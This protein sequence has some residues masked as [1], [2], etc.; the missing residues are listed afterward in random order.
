MPAHW[1]QDAKYKRRRARA[2]GGSSYV[3]PSRDICPNISP[4]EAAYI[5]IDP[6]IILEKNEYG[7]HSLIDIPVYIFRIWLCVQEAQI[8]ERIRQLTP[9]VREEILKLYHSVMD[10]KADYT[11]PTAIIDQGQEKIEFLRI[12]RVALPPNMCPTD[13]TVDIVSI[14]SACYV[15]NWFSVAANDAWFIFSRGTPVHADADYAR[16]T[17]EPLQRYDPTTS[18]CK[19][20]ETIPLWKEGEWSKWAELT[21]NWIPSTEPV[22]RVEV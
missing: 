3:P 20:A 5:P 2:A 19:T 6:Y 12:R 9:R 14:L 18:C 15:G 8:N 1:H 17:A 11:E 4:R 22:K 21:H 10:L 7:E 16:L 13:V